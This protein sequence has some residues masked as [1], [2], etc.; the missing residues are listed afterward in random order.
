[1]S[2]AQTEENLTI[3]QVF[4]QS[5]LQ[6]PNLQLIKETY[7]V[8]CEEVFKVLESEESIKEYQR[9]NPDGGIRLTRYDLSDSGFSQTDAAQ[10]ALEFI[11]GLK[12]FREEQKKSLAQR[13]DHKE[14]EIIDELAKQFDQKMTLQLEEEIP[15]NFK[16][17]FTGKQ[18]RST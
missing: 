9:N 18:E 8:K 13:M 10:S 14:E 11:S 5:S 2:S 6:K 17:V 12:Q 3:D 15:S 1:M 16:P 7:N 4:S